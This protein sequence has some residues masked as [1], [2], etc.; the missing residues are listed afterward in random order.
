MNAAK[1]VKR[2]SAIHI[3]NN[4]YLL[5]DFATTRLFKDTLEYCDQC[6]KIVTANELEYKNRQFFVKDCSEALNLDWWEQIKCI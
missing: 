3:I 6:G 5:F 2:I 1:K 4:E